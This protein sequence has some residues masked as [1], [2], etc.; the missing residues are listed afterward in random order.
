MSEIQLRC[1]I[2]GYV[3]PPSSPRPQTDLHLHR[4]RQSGTGPAGSRPAPAEKGGL[5]VYLF[6]GCLLTLSVLLVVSTVASIIALAFFP[7]F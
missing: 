1:D 7:F 3:T 2:C 6:L 5:P 4:C